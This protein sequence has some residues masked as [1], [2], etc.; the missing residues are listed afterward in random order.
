MDL[1]QN[2]KLDK[3]RTKNQRLKEIYGRSNT[4]IQICQGNVLSKYYIAMISTIKEI[5]IGEYFVFKTMIKE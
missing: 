1:L 3:L 2:R 5:I 4:K